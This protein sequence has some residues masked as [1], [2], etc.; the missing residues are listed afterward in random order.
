MKKKSLS[1]KQACSIWNKAVTS[2]DPATKGTKL[3]DLSN[4][5]KNIAQFPVLI[6]GK[7]V[8]S[9]IGQKPQAS[10]KKA[11]AI[12]KRAN[13]DM[14]ANEVTI[15]ESIR[16][17]APKAPKKVVAKSTKSKAKTPKA[18]KPKREKKKGICFYMTKFILEGIASGNQLTAREVAEKVGPLVDREPSTILHI[19]R[20]Q[21]GHMKRRGEIADDQAPFAS[22]VSSGVSAR[23]RELADGTRSAHEI[24]EVLVEE[25]S[26]SLKSAKSMVHSIGFADRKKGLPTNIIS[27]RERIKILSEQLSCQEI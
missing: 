9:I 20:A 14:T 6:N 15:G 17:E 2:D 18:E 13:F 25:F 3:Q 24:A 21:A 4:A 23:V 7:P 16:E 27:E 11:V 12:L 22:A 26:K 10:L 8:G 1:H 5:P 19:V